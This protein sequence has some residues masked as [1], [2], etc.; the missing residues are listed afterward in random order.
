MKIVDV[1][2][3]GNGKTYGGKRELGSAEKWLSKTS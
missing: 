2:S 1:N 3:E